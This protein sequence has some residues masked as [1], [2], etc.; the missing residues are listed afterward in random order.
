[1]SGDGASAARVDTVGRTDRGKATSDAGQLT[2]VIFSTLNDCRLCTVTELY[3]V[4]F[5]KYQECS[6]HVSS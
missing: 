3:N 6:K 5:G 2:L 4:M 1:M